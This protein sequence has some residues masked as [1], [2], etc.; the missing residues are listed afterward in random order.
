MKG[1]Q[2]RIVSG[3]AGGLWIKLPRH[4]KSRPTQD[5]V[6]QA[7]FSSLGALVPEA[8]V[9]DLCAGSGA[10]GI[11]SLSRGAEKCVFVDIDRNCTA[12]IKENL[13]YCKLSGNIMTLSAESFLQGNDC[14]GFQIVFFDPPY[15]KERVDLAKTPT[16]DL[17][18][19]RLAPGTRLIWEHDNLNTWSEHPT[20]RL[21]KH[22]HYGD[23][24]VLFLEV[25]K[26]EKN[27]ES[28]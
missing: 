21:L 5:R 24:G 13:T 9:L 27:S 23:T 2:V 7:V 10:Y 18:A 26:V 20:L 1:N 28:L 14:S 4:F 8:C 15:L 17:F 3:S 6:R 11:E 12:A 16:S 19:A 22:N 25:T